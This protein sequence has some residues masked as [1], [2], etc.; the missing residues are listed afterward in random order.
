LVITVSLLAAHPADG[1]LP[2]AKMALFGLTVLGDALKR[3]E[4]T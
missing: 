4:T 1:E 2:A 3:T